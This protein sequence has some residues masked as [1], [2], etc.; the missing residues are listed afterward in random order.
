MSLTSAL[1]SVLLSQTAPG[2]SPFSVEVAGDCRDA[3]ACQDARWSSF[4]GTWVRQES[5]ESAKSRYAEIVL[6]AVQAAD[7]L[8]CVSGDDEPLAGCV[9][10]PGVRSRRGLRWEREELSAMSL[11]VAIIESGLREDVQVGRGS[12]R[13]PSDDGGRGRGPGREA[14]L[15]QIHPTIAQRFADVPLVRLLGRDEESLR[16]CFLTGMRM[17]IRA[18]AFCAGQAP[19][20]PWDWATMA[21]YGTGNSCT[22]AN[23]GKTGIRANLYRRMIVQVRAK[24]RAERGK[25]PRPSS[26]PQPS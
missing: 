14:C 16:Q 10:Y 24:I 20:A 12:A 1:L 5:R 25:Q 17:L 21:M 2:G 11:S 4:Y 23:Q 15:L 13:K 7:E 19:R 22:S 8:L 3:Q 26:E 9:P 6:A 18:R